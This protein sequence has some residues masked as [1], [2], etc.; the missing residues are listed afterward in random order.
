MG[1]KNLHQFLVKNC[2]HCI[3]DITLKD[4]QGKTIA[5]DASIIVYKFMIACGSNNMHLLSLR[6]FID[7][8]LKHNIKPIFV[9]DGKPPDE[10]SVTLN[11]RKEKAK[12]SGVSALVCDDDFVVMRQL[13]KAMGV[14]CIDAKGEAE[15]QCALMNKHGLVDCVASEDM[16]T[17]CFGA[18]CLIR[19]LNAS[20]KKIQMYNLDDIITSLNMRD[21]NEFI[22]FCIL[23]G[24]DY[25]K[26]IPS[27][28]QVRGYNL[29]VK[30]RKTLEDIA[31]ENNLSSVEY[32]KTRDLFIN[33][34]YH[35]LKSL[36]N[37]TRRDD[38]LV[39][40]IVDKSKN[41]IN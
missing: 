40:G 12:A 41:R 9:F 10:K 25:I 18:P 32:K 22:N 38:E 20:G 26:T 34:E 17:L 31:I 19:N 2:K 24:C 6:N 21:M 15:A 28:G 8:L 29:I 1:I 14:P 33:P 36:P 27:I 7:K 37:L 4:L 16:D 13:I 23:C 35:E 39:N 5:I 30:Q 3:K 11:D